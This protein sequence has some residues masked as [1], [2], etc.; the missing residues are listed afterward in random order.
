METFP[1]TNLFQYLKRI[2]DVWLQTFVISLC[3]LAPYWFPSVDPGRV[4]TSQTVLLCVLLSKQLIFY[5]IKNVSH[6][7]VIFHLK[8]FLCSI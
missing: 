1:V 3:L 4:T 2:S 5:F 8:A 6:K 7:K